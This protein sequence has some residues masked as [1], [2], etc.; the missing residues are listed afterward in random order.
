MLTELDNGHTR[1]QTWERFSGVLGVLVRWTVLGAVQ[2]GFDEM[3]AALAGYVE[4][5][6]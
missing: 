4:S 5:Q 3:A 1:Y 2:R 6:G